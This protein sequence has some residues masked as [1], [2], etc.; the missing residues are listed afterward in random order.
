MHED[1]IFSFEGCS[2]ID[3]QNNTMITIEPILDGPDEVYCLDSFD[4]SASVDGDPGN[5]DAT[6]PGNVVFTNANSQNT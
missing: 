1:Y 3:S 2:G 6:G 4:L 5:W